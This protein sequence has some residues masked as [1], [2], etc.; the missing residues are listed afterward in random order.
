M[1]LP[2]VIRCQKPLAF[3]MRGCELL[4]GH[5]GLCTADTRMLIF[6]LPVRYIPEPVLCLIRPIFG[7]QNRKKTLGDVMDEQEARRTKKS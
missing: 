5:T 4:K 1:N 7:I 6:Y 2:N 3:Q